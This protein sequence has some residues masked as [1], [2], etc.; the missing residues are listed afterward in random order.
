MWQTFLVVALVVIVGVGALSWVVGRFHAAAGTALSLVAGLVGRIAVAAV[1]AYSTAKAVS[2]GGWFILL[3]AVFF[4]IGLAAVATSVLT[5]A[6]L[7]ALA[8]GR[9]PI[10]RSKPAK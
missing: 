9:A 2:H 6:A 7:R 8:S 3:S 5:A 4:V 10:E 1:M